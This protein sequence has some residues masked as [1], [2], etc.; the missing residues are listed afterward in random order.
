MTQKF[1]P[2][3]VPLVTVDPF[4]SIWSFSDELTREVTRHWT[5]TRNAMTA[6]LKIDGK[7]FICM[8][9]MVYSNKDYCES[10]PYIKQTNLHITPTSTVYT[11][12]NSLLKLTL[13]FTTPLLLDDLVL[14]SRPVSYVRYNVEPKT[15]GDHDIEFYF[16]IGT[17]ACID[18]DRQR[19]KFGRTDYSMYCGNIDQ[20]PLNKSGDGGRI[21]WGYLHLCRTDA[22]IGNFSNR[23]AFC[24]EGGFIDAFSED[25]TYGLNASLAVICKGESDTIALAYDDIYSINY[26]GEKL[27]AFYKTKY[28]SFDEAARAAIK[29]ADEIF[30]RCEKFD[31]EFTAKL[32]KY[33]EDYKNVGTL[34]YRQA[35]AAHK[36]C[37]GKNGEV[38]FFSK[39]CYSGGFIA[40]LDVTYPSIPLFLLLN[41]ELVKGMIRPIVS[42][43]KTERWIYDFAPHDTGL[44]PFATGQ[45]YSTRHGDLIPDE[46]MPVEECGN[47][48]LTVAAICRAEG[49]NA[50][51]EENREFMEKW[52]EYL[53]KYGYNPENQLCTDDFAGHFAHNCNLSLKAIA[54]LAAYGKLTGNARYTD[55]AYDM[56][57]RF[58]V[59]AA[60]EKA[61]R[62]AF[63]R[64]GT[65]SLKYNLVWDRLLGL[66]LFSDEFY[67]REIA[68]YKEK[69]NEYGVPLDNRKTYTKLDWEAWTTVLTED[70][71]YHDMIFSRI[72]KM[73]TDTQVRVPITDWYDT[74]TSFQSGF[75]NRTVLGGFYINMLK[76][77]WLGN[78]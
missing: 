9:N 63:D 36:I 11:F 33:G 55:T 51:A 78:N 7:P 48:I 38:L 77:A 12:E 75:Q 45:M 8:G 5:G 22:F 14:A 13:T 60:D 1:R 73:I 50:F 20:R 17:D 34:A 35:I 30:E 44:Y 70:A 18:S 25:V 69:M 43:A 54:A 49:S 27:D 53:I 29:D 57:R 71:E 40:T 67:A 64:E 52:A 59:E 15:E 74:I 47:F 10:F 6:I 65:W 24:R 42:E 56:A 39:E 3:S 26:Y 61:T 41:P 46:Q 23:R 28:S 66:D 4:F 72:A 19:A 68:L 58:E 16:D 31:R 76:D 37:A 2:V 32:S 21:D 62:L